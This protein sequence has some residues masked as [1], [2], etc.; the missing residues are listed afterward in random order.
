MEDNKTSELQVELV[1]IG[2]G[3]QHSDSALTEVVLEDQVFRGINRHTFLA[4][5]VC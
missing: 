1:N 3:P 2:S 5:L 4:F